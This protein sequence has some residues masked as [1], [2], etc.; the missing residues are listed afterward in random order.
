MIITIDGPA[1]AGK[2]T[3]ARLLAEKLTQSGGTV[4]EYLDTG[5]M[6][7]AV[8]LLG[9]RQNDAWN[10]PEKLLKLAEN[11]NIRVENGKTF[12]N[13]EDVTQKVRDAAVTE[14]TR[15]A[16]DHPGVRAIM[17]RLQQQMGRDCLSQKRGLVTE[18]RDQGSVVFPEA[19]CKIFLTASPEERARRRL[20]E[21]Q[22]RGQSGDFDAILGQILARD[23]RDQARDV[24]P[25]CEPEDAV[26]VIT[27]KM[28][29]TAVVDH[30]AAIVLSR[31]RLFS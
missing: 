1:G 6:Y 16:A 28:S 27:D 20:G 10:R 8:T 29:I 25:L 2:S 13:G 18:G 24:G 4:F 23:A 7:R 30:I 3:I 11:A 26:R 22:Q 5:S 19:G 9:L 31:Q 12:L 15:F 21:M 17:V 14:K